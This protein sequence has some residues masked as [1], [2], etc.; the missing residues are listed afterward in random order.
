MYIHPP[1][2]AAPRLRH[3]QSRSASGGALYPQAT[4][5]TAPHKEQKNHTGV[6]RVVKGYFNDK[7]FVR[8]FRA[9]VEGRQ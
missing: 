3:L 2:V 9:P 5:K 8:K 7:Q 1:S 6:L 4:R